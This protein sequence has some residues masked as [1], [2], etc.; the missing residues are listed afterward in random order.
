[1]I[2]T[3]ELSKMISKDTYETI[4]P[5][6]HM[7]RYESCFVTTACAEQ[8]FQTIRLYKMKNKMNTGLDMLQVSQQDND[9]YMYLYMIAISINPSK[10]FGGDPHSS[11]DILAFNHGFV[12]TIYRKIFELIPCLEV[13]PEQSF[14]AGWENL[15]GR[16]IDEEWLRKKEEQSQQWFTDNAFKVHRIDFAFDIAT[17]AQEYLTMINTGYDLSKYERIYF[18]EQMV[19]STEA[20]DKYVANVSYVYFKNK[21]KGDKGT[22]LNIYHKK[23]ELQKE[24]IPHNPNGDY[25]FLR[26]E[27][28]AKKNKLHDI[29]SKFGLPDRQLQ[30]LATPEVEEYLLTD[31][32]KQLTKNGL[33]VT[34]SFAEKIIDGSKYSA[35][36]KARLK[37]LIDVLA[38]SDTE[39][40]G[41]AA[42]LQKVE[43]R[44]F[45]DLGE[46]STVKQYL[47]DIH[48][49]GINPLTVS[50]GMGVSEVVF[51]NLGDGED[52]SEKVLL[53]LID[54]IRTYCE[55]VRQ[56][57]QSMIDQYAQVKDLDK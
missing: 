51:Q 33:Y 54:I 40:D 1:M 38:G 16:S 41:I 4:I 21:S 17:N 46:V 52:I 31:Y 43:D 14:E 5:L 53:P 28:Q 56:E 42:V 19:L 24:Q 7:N 48:K 22:T 57:R 18:E 13:N 26:I 36:K 2:H 37:M 32:A 15:Q 20:T 8:G 27:I 11:T 3:F 39:E 9:A 50:E 30:Y 49:L 10:M 55:T 12:R 45:T 35:K 34:H 6:L 47:R 23:T 25:D 29:V 44:T